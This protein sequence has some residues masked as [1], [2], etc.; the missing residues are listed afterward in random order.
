MRALSL[1]GCGCRG[2]F[3][4][5]VLARLA[6]AGE[7]FDLVGGASSGSLAG[8]AYVAGKSLDGPA[9]YRTLASTQVAS[10]RWLA[11]EKSPFG[12][13]RIVLESLARHIPERD[14]TSGEAELL[15]STTRLVA[16]LGSLASRRAAGNR[17]A[18]V[19]HSSRERASFH[20]VL[21]A[22]CTFPP[23]Y[24]RLPRIDGEI[25]VDGGATDN[26]LI[27][28]LVARG[29]THITVITPHAAGTVYR[30]LFQRVGAPAVPAHVEL[31]VIRPARPLRLRSF[32][33]DPVRLEEALGTPHVATVSR[34]RSAD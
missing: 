9:I 31:R 21:L 6:A 16:F 15:V 26:T 10:P 34:P 4:F 25:H 32:D 2:A 24:A 23:F 14:I 22:S 7:R 28:A 20:D 33:F 1:P 8:A 12:M 29:A 13:S 18:A 11:S 27:E 17:G 30:G 19:I 3:Q 5:A